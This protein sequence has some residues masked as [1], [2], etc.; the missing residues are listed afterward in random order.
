[1]SQYASSFYE[2]QRTI[3]EVGQTHVT[4]RESSGR[5]RVARIVERRDG[6]NGKPVSLLLDRVVHE[7]WAQVR[8]W[9]AQGCF[10]TELIDEEIA[11]ARDEEEETRRRQE[12][13]ARGAERQEEDETDESHEQA[14]TPENSDGEDDDDEPDDETPDPDNGDESPVSPGEGGRC[15]Y[16]RSEDIEGT[17]HR[18][19]YDGGSNQITCHTCEAIWNEVFKLDT[20]DECDPPS[21]GPVEVLVMVKGEATER[22][23]VRLE[24]AVGH[25]SSDITPMRGHTD[26]TFRVTTVEAAVKLDEAASKLRF[27]EGVTINNQR[28]DSGGLPLMSDEQRDKIRQRTSRPSRM[29]WWV[30][31]TH[32]PVTGPMSSWRPGMTKPAWMPWTWPTATWKAVGT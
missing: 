19:D 2:P 20:I 14:Q 26:V 31:T 11:K 23:I 28:A 12:D 4:L 24:K 25:G 1:M 18:D 13:E 21:G 10:V 27:V 7:Q 15:P 9:R 29:T 16:C 17:G 6:P 30:L 22:Q 8:G 32:R 5:T 3:V